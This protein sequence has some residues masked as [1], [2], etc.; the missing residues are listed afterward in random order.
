MTKKALYINSLLLL[1]FISSVR[2]G[3]THLNQFSNSGTVTDDHILETKISVL[4]QDQTYKNQSDSIRWILE[5]SHYT[6][7]RKSEIK[8]T[9]KTS[10]NPETEDI[11]TVKD[12]KLLKYDF[13]IFDQK[14]GIREL[15]NATVHGINQVLKKS[16]EES[17]NLGSIEVIFLNRFQENILIIENEKDSIW[18][19]KEEI[20]IFFHPGE[21]I[22]YSIEIHPVKEYHV[23]YVETS[24]G[25]KNLREIKNPL[26]HITNENK[27][28]LLYYYAP[29]SP[30]IITSP[31]DLSSF[32]NKLFVSIT[33]P[34]IPSLELRRLKNLIKRQ[35]PENMSKMSLILHFY[36]GEINYHILSKYLV[37]PFISDYM[38]TIEVRDISI[39]IYTDFRVKKPN[40]YYIYKNIMDDADP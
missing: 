7:R 32:Y 39:N 26:D 6:E 37:D 21:S 5:M 20:S 3:I 27:D 29:Q 30:M 18:E 17:I 2:C 11:P 13:E 16:L 4:T 24:G 35:M 33:Q 34:P 23:F 10:I 38:S 22:R 9:D 28:F 14:K 36:L 1:F 25:I 19:D 8:N 15:K 31:E 12:I 40:K